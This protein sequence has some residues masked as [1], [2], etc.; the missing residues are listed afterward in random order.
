VCN[1]VDGLV[2]LRDA[3]AADTEKVMQDYDDEVVERFAKA[4][5][6][7]LQEAETSFDLETIWKMLM[8]TRG[9]EGTA[10]ALEF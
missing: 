5:W 10:E 9:H 7:S 8:V 1:Y 6:Q 2:R 3:G 4:V